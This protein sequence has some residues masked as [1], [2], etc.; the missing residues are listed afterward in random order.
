[1]N[2]ISIQ[3]ATI[4]DIQK[5][6]GIDTQAFNKAWKMQT[7]AD[8]LQKDYAFYYICYIDNIAVGYAGI[9]CIYETAELIRIATLPDYRKRG[10]ADSLMKAIL[11][12]SAECGCENM[13]LEVRA[14]NLTAQNLY[15][16]NRI[17]GRIIWI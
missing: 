5:L 8:E 9:W 10:I 16:K 1:M 2:N 11:K 6:V 7:F 15:K 14:S 12:K 3:Q 13:M 4:D 17:R